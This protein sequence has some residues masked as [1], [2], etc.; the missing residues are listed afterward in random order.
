MPKTEVVRVSSP[1]VEAAREAGMVMG[2]TVAD[3]VSH[4]TRL[5]RAVEAA[6]ARTT[7][8]HDVLDGQARFDDLD[9]EDQAAV[10]EMWGHRVS[11]L[12]GGLDLRSEFETNGQ[13]YAE[14]DE[15]GNVVTVGRR[16]EQRDAHRRSEST[17]SLD[18]G[19]VHKVAPG[20][21]AKRSA[22]AEAVA[23]KKRSGVK[24]SSTKRGSVAK[25]SPTNRTVVQ[26]SS[27][28][29]AAAKRRVAI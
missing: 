27:A 18:T 26:R 29:Q 15:D 3:Q 17:R 16:S 28:K 23:K 14:L 9:G 1:L 6:G 21:E 11:E 24:K 13:A 25:K 19:Q 20:K 8:I 7:A 2:R 12:L 4:W 5:G 22:A 10:A